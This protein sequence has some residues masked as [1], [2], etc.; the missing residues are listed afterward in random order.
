MEHTLVTLYSLLLPY[1]IA[2]GNASMDTTQK[3]SDCITHVML[4]TILM[5]QMC[6]C[7]YLYLIKP[8]WSEVLGQGHQ[9]AAN[10]VNDRP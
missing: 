3:I 10:V 9:L 6:N 1:T 2:V 4:L 5:N 8:H 7:K